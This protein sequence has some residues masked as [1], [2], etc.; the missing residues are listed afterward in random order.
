MY[1]WTEGLDDFDKQSAG[2]RTLVK[3]DT[4]GMFNL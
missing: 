2:M 1:R 4:A 3:V